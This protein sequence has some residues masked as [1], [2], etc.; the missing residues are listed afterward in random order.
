MIA[1]SDLNIFADRF[2]PRLWSLDPE[3]RTVADIQDFDVVY[4]CNSTKR[5]DVTDIDNG[6]DSR[7]WLKTPVSSLSKYAAGIGPLTQF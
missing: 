5:V 4:T 6:P 7:I 3:D 1:F 2:L